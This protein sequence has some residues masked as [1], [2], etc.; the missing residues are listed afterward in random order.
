[1]IFQVISKLS[2]QWLIGNIPW[3]DDKSIVSHWCPHVVVYHY[4]F[5][6]IFV[7]GSITCQEF[8]S[9]IN[10][11]INHAS[12]SI[13]LSNSLRTYSLGTLLVVQWL[14]LCTPNT[15]GPS[16]IPGRATRSHMP[17]YRVQMPTQRRLKTPS[18]TVK[19]ECSQT[20]KKDLSIKFICKVVLSLSEF[21]EQTHMMKKPSE[22]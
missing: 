3:T 7:R 22:R 20:N 14:R 1:M 11:L 18:A 17:Q 19:I 4:M 8:Q 13:K 16:S 15:G 5:Y 10:V 21:R 9:F 2:V 6:V 12:S